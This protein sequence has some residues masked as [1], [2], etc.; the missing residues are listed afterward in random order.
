M[1]V[2]S[3]LIKFSLAETAHTMVETYQNND[4]DD[5]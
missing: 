4:T 3:M 5:C 2:M 1:D